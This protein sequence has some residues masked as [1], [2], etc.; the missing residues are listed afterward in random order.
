MEEDD[1]NVA[2]RHGCIF[3]EANM[4]GGGGGGKL[5]ITTDNASENFSLVNYAFFSNSL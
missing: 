5:R 3:L 2:L 4:G 1:L